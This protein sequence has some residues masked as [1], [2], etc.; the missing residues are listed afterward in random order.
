[1][2]ISVNVPEE[3]EQR[4]HEGCTFEAVKNSLDALAIRHMRRDSLN[5]PPSLQHLSIEE[6]RERCKPD[7]DR[8]AWDIMYDHR[9]GYLGEIAMHL[10]LEKDWRLV[11]D[12]NRLDR[13][14]YEDGVVG[15]SLRYDVKTQH[16][17]SE[18]KPL[19]VKDYRISGPYACNYYIKCQLLKD[20]FINIIGYAR[21]SQFLKKEP[22]MTKYGLYRSVE[23]EELRDIDP[24]IEHYRQSLHVD[25]GYRAWLKQ[26]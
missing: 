21:L 2:A 12:F 25:A 3:V 17:D 1:M 7:V 5:L 4:M 20:D 15:R 8:A 14:N 16:K 6:L 10:Q 26:H 18:L 22:Y 11:F 9:V 23:I 19:S 13:L 24:F